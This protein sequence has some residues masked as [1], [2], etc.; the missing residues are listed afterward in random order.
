[1]PFIACIFPSHLSTHPLTHSLF[2]HIL[3]PTHNHPHTYSHPLTHLRTH[4]NTHRVA[5]LTCLID[6]S[7]VSQMHGGQPVKHAWM[8]WKSLFQ[9]S[10]TSPSS[11]WTATTLTLVCDLHVCVTVFCSSFHIARKLAVC[12]AVYR[13]GHTK[14]TTSGAHDV[15]AITSPQNNDLC[16]KEL[17]NIYVA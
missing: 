16:T 5:I 14:F 13:L 15:I 7:T 6:C 17:R 11:W 9:S 10:S 2:T 8:M 1:M 4:H 12:V 3:P